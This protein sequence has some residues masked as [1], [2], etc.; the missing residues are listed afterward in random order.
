MMH[1]GH[2]RLLER[3]KQLGGYLIVGVTTEQ[4]DESR[5]KLSVADTLTERIRNVQQT[6]FADEI[7]V[8]DHIG[9]KVED[10]IR[11]N[12]DIF[13]IGSD[14]KGAF[15]YLADYCEV[16]YLE[17][18]KDISSSILRAKKYP[19]FR[20]GVIGTG[21]IA[22][23]FIPESKYVSG[24]NIE[25]VYNP[26]IESAKR[27]ADQYEL[28]SSTDDWNEFINKIDGVYIASPH[29][30]HFYY[31]IKALE[32]NKHV[33]CEKPMCLRSDQATA[34]FDLAQ[35]KALVLLEA[36]KTAYCPGFLRLFSIVKS[37]VI[38]QIKDIDATFTKL[39]PENARE[40]DELNGGAFL[41]YASYPLL[42]ISKILGSDYK[43]LHFESLYKGKTDYYTKAFFKYNEAMATAK[44]G[45]G[46]KSEGNLVISGTKGYV[47]VKS[48]WWKTTKFDICFE[49]TSLN[50]P[51]YNK[52]MDDGLRY[53]LSAFLSAVNN[54]TNK[55]EKST[56]SDSIFAANVFEKFLIH[57]NCSI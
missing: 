40:W 12:V 41:E 35:Q 42:A 52:F 26:H 8:E 54:I 51:F 16:I 56:K 6:G 1:N 13:A 31:S 23:R 11:Y 14:W 29:E 45:I 19:I 7:I 17:R 46:V 48:P 4:Y 28:S 32:A 30:T 33:L 25:S 22:S 27:F 15:D 2:Y 37:G 21:R 9:Q 39:H 44:V 43:T 36:L 18:T 53:E 57:Q 10:I 34:L 24:V 49:D 5:G 20:L 38:G 47:I 50:E 3:A 55:K